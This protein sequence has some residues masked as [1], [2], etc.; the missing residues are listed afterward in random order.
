MSR[1]WSGISMRPSALTSCLISSIGNSGAKSAGPIGWPVPG[2]STGGGGAGRSDA[3]LYQLWGMSFSANVYLIESMANTS[4]L[5][6]LLSIVRGPLSVATDDGQRTTDKTK[7][8]HPIQGREDRSLSRCHPRSPDLA[9]LAHST[10]MRHIACPISC[11]QITVA[12]PAATTPIVN[13]ILQI[14]NRQ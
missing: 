14:A 7:T 2:C 4:S 6:Y 11:A 9:A 1:T 8:P 12:S 10:D 13:C 3:M 5:S